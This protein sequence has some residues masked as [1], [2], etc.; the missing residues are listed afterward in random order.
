M[1]GVYYSYCWMSKLIC[2]HLHQI[3]P[4]QKRMVLTNAFIN[5]VAFMYEGF[6]ELCASNSCWQSCNL[7]HSITAI[8]RNLQS[9]VQC[10]LLA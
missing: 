8:L 1:F 2:H 9:N 5:T 7:K 3:I 4:M 6:R 10:V